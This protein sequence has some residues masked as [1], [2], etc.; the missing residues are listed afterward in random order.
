[1]TNQTNTN[2]DA[3]I[4]YPGQNGAR[5]CLTCSY[6]KSSNT[7]GRCGCGEARKARGEQPAAASDLDGIEVTW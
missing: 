3:A 6:C 1:M 2:T 4:T 7:W 5:G